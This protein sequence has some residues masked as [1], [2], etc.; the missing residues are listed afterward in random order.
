MTFGRRLVKRLAFLALGVALVS[1]ANA[2]APMLKTQAPGWYRMM[3]GD[4]EI[5]VL[6]DGVLGLEP[7]KLVQ[8]IKAEQV[9]AY[10]KRAFQGDSIPVSVNAYLVNTGT[11]LVMVD[12]GSGTLFGPTLGYLVD[13]LKAAGYLPEQ[14][15]DILITHLHGD[16]MGGL[17][18]EGKTVFPNAVVHVDQHDADFWLSQANLDKAEKDSKQYFQ[19]AQDSINPYI[20]AGRFK[21]FE[22]ATEFTPGIKSVPAHGHTPGHTFYAIESKGE[23]M[24]TWGDLVHVPAVQFPEPGVTVSFDSDTKAAAAARK[25]AFA[26]AAKTGILIGSAHLTFPG[27]GHLRAEGKGYVFVP[28]DYDSVHQ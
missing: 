12:A 6:S 17:S 25:A 11:K 19:G 13:N 7:K 15:D 22:G 10:L 28:L 20:A 24:I 8:N 26:D 27:L 14:V 1:S 23:R 2:A 18:K 3:L 5:T 4:F 21:P 9:D 16:H